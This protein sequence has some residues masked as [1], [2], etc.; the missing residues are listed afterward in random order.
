MAIYERYTIDLSLS[1]K[2]K[3][4]AEVLKTMSFDDRLAHQ[5]ALL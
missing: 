3:T 2:D 5:V 4:T 1:T